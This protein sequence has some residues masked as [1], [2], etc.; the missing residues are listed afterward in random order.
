MLNFLKKPTRASAPNFE[1]RRHYIFEVPFDELTDD[2]VVCTCA[3]IT[4]R[5]VKQE[6]EFGIDNADELLRD[7]DAGNSCRKCVAYLELLIAHAKKELGI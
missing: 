3:K 4:Y 1:A 2:S 6:L 5:D 7:L